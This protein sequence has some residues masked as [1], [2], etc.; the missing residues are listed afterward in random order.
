M[1]KKR[2]MISTFYQGPAVKR[3]ITKLSPDKIIL[4]IDDSLKGSGTEKMKNALEELKK[5]YSEILGIQI[6]KVKTYDLPQIIEKASKLITKENR[7]NNEIII[8]ITEGRKITSLG[9]LFASY[10]NKSKVSSA[11]YITEEENKLISLPM[12]DFHIGSSKKEI[13]KEV[14][15]G[16]GVVKRIQEKL[17]IKQSA[18]YQHLQELRNEGYIENDKELKLS[19]FGRVVIL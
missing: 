18:V 14:N 9:L 3:A 4:L 6:E 1:V 7:L 16:N 10:L 12:L 8:H 19:E 13:L 2:V 17:K 5:F 11:F 15:K